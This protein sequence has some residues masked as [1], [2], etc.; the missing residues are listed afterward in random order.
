MSNTPAKRSPQN[1]L[2]SQAEKRRS[3][4]DQT[5]AFLQLGGSIQS[6]PNGASG[7]VWKSSRDISLA[8][9]PASTDGQ[10]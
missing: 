10:A 9:K 4:E 1:S 8:K 2:P 6:I 7:Q 5:S 3:I